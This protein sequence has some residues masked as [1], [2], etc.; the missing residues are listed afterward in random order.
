MSFDLEPL[1][2]DLHHLAEK[3]SLIVFLE[4]GRVESKQPEK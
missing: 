1:P 3:K 2:E 4:S